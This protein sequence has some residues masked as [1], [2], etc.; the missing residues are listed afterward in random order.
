MEKPLK[1]KEKISKK[2]EKKGLTKQ[3][4]F[5]IILERFRQGAQNNAQG[6]KKVGE[7]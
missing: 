7:K 5:V 3:G 4:V 1:N 6:N 2:S